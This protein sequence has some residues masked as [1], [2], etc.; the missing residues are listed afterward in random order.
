MAKSVPGVDPVVIRTAYDGLRSSPQ[1]HCTEDLTRQADAGECDIRQIMKR[2]E[3]TGVL[4]MGREI[5]EASYRDNASAPSFD[6]AQGGVAAVRGN[7]SLLADDV[8][9]RFGHRAEN[10]L[11]AMAF[12]AS[13]EDGADAVRA[14]LEA[15]GVLEPLPV[16]GDGQDPA[17]RGKKA[18]H[19][20]GL[21]KAVPTDRK[22][23]DDE[24]Q[25]DGQEREPEGVPAERK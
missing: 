1:I 6:A 25:E 22:G 3:Q 4:P 24:T 18:R 2:Y 20:A 19:S 10:M 14:E 9:A 7:F 21:D 5:S 23:S 13:G 15:L 16:V 8:Q 11:E 12:A 17:I